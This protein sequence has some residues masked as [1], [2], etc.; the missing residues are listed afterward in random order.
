MHLLYLFAVGAKKIILLDREQKT[1]EQVTITNS[2][3]SSLFDHDD[4]VVSAGPK[5]FSSHLSQKKPHPLSRF[6]LNASFQNRRFKLTSLL[7]FLT[8]KNDHRPTLTGDAFRTFGSISCNQER[9]TECLACLNECKIKALSADEHHFSLN[10]EASRC[11]QCQ[12]CV[13]ICPEDALETVP[14]LR[15]H[16]DFFDT[17]ELARA[18]PMRCKECS[19]IF[20]TRKSF[21]RVMAKLSAKNMMADEM[22]LFE[23]CDTCRVVKIYESQNERK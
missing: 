19:K 7:Q 6:Y 8:E 4:T 11:V 14:G 18:E 20:G 21:D 13:E 1:T 10:L 5:N 16:P 9:C 2:I 15:L 12:T 17:K 3:I 22:Q 23:Y